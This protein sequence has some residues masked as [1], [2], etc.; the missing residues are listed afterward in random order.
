MQESKEIVAN[1][2]NSRKDTS[3][4]ARKCSKIINLRNLNNAIKSLLFEQYLYRGCSVL[5]LCGGKGGD[6]GK[7]NKAGVSKVVLV[8]IAEQSIKD[9]EDRYKKMKNSFTCQFIVA[10]CHVAGVH[11]MM[12]TLH[13]GEMFDIVN[14]QFALHYSWENEERANGLL[15][16][17]AVRLKT[18]GYFLCTIPDEY[19]L[20][21]LLHKTK[22]KLGFGNSIYSIKFDA[23]CNAS[24]F[25]NRYIFNLVDAVSNCPEYLVDIKQLTKMAKENGLTLINRRNFSDI[26]QNYKRLNKQFSGISPSRDE[27]EVAS[28]YTVLIFQK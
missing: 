15:K 13:P 1:H 22:D 7:F 11:H 17:A 28:L 19:A 5:D 12:H 16:N 18:G 10:D 23:A 3:V 8:D 25:G 6:L 14:C 27:F 4:V 21:Q 24:P 20:L 26:Y 9:A 2:Y